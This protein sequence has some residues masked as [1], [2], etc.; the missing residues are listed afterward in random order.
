MKKLIIVIALFAIAGG[1]FAADTGGVTGAVVRGTITSVSGPV[2]TLMRNVKVDVSSAV[3]TRG[4]QT[5]T[6]DGLVVG[7]RI[8]A[9]IS[10]SPSGRPGVLPAEAVSVDPDEGTIIGPLTSL[11]STAVTLDGQTIAVDSSTMYDGYSN[12]KPVLSAADITAGVPVSVEVASVPNGLVALEVRVLS[13][14]PLAPPAPPLDEATIT[15]TVTAIGDEV[16]TVGATKVNIT[17]KTTISDTPA[18]KV[19]DTV[20]VTGVKL[21]DGALIAS[22]ITRK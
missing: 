19:G 6:A 21:P 9:V 2:V 4:R 17:Q 16:W 14:A 13:P 12:Q 10:P 22:T 11:T 7:S 5:M 15:G 3:V 20:D 1:A 18:P 8:L